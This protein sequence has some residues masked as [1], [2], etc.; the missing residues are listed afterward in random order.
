MKVLHLLASGSTGGI[1]TLCKDY[2]MFSKLDNTFLF[3]WSTGC[4]TDE[5]K[6]NKNNV[7]ELHANKKNI[8][9]PLRNILRICKDRKIEA[10]VVHHAA[11][12]AH[13]YLMIIKKIY[14][15]ITT[16]AYAHGNANDMRG[17]SS[18]RGILLRRKIIKKSLNK[19]DRVI[20]I[21][22]S[23]K[24]S[25]MDVYN[26]QSD[27]INVIYN[28]VNVKKFDN[29]IN[30]KVPDT[31]EIIYVGRL[32]KQKGVQNII[33]V[34]SLL[35]KDIKY[36]FRIIGD[37]IYREELEHEVKEYG[38]ENNIEFYGNRRDVP[39]LLATSDI[40]MHLPEWEEGFGITIVEAMSAGLITICR[41]YGAI[42]E[43]ID[44]S[45][46]GYLVELKDL[47]HVSEIIQ[48]ISKSKDD[49]EY[50]ILRKNAVKKAKSFSINSYAENMDEMI[51]TLVSKCNHHTK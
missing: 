24:Q 40:F 51:T 32:I 1:E 6:K 27:K 42:P 18:N 29:N 26:V 10:V 28:G 9:G 5:M 21:S 45:V 25:L 20:A 36:R 30:Q 41:N 17:G 13:L 37:G 50:K 11:P 14:P 34:L 33:K 23:V 19:A 31:L 35:P 7:V 16:I 48:K 12:V 43:I 8:L 39:Q 3:I 22:K 44:D 47:E 15:Q 4:I 2:A 46:N 38:L 49:E